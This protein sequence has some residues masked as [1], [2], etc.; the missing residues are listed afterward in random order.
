MDQ[1]A[2]RRCRRWLPLS[3]FPSRTSPS[4]SRKA[5]CKECKATGYKEWRLANHEQLLQKK[6]DDYYAN[7]DKILKLRKVAKN[8]ARYLARL[9]QEIFNHYGNACYC[10]GLDDPRFLTVEHLSNDG[11]VS[12]YAN[13]KRKSGSSMYREIIDA[14]FPEDIALACYNCN[15]AR[16]HIGRGGICPHKQPWPSSQN[17]T[18]YFI[19]EADGKVESGFYDIPTWVPDDIRNDPAEQALA[20]SEAKPIQRRSLRRNW[21]KQP[22]L[23]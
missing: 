11:H 21:T 9:K 15:C 17:K 1:K 5:T 12:R 7:R 6:R 3:D 18:T 20:T 4:S 16:A 13:G 2:C 14:G 22:K 10:C 19:D 8:G 23:F